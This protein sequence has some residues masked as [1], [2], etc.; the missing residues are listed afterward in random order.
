MVCIKPAIL[1]RKIERNVCM[2]REFY[3]KMLYKKYREA[4]KRGGS[5]RSD[6]NFGLHLCRLIFF[7]LLFSGAFSACE[8]D[9]V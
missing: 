6:R 2:A 9:D 3:L 8:V 5:R 7:F 1:G 4:N